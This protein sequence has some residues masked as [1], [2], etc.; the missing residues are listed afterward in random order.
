MALQPVFVG[1]WTFKDGTAGDVTQ[2]IILNVSEELY[3]ALGSPAFNSLLLQ[4]KTQT[5]KNGDFTYPKQGVRNGKTITLF[6][7]ADLPAPSTGKKTYQIQFND[8]CP[9][10][11]LDRYLN[12]AIGF[13][14]TFTHWKIRGGRKTVIGTTIVT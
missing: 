10:Y 2:P 4:G 12:D 11:L 7:D 13:N 5:N 3:A 9:A 1:N 8:S 6:T 14:D